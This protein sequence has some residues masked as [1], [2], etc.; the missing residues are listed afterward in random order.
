MT[1]FT[2]PPIS[3]P[4]TS[5][6]VYTRSRSLMRRCCTSSA[7]ATSENA[8]QVADGWPAITSWARMAR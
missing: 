7:F 1:F 3:Q 2:A 8:T 4:M 6:L 5:G